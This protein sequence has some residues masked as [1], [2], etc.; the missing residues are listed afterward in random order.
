MAVPRR[1][2]NG[3]RARGYCANVAAALELFDTLERLSWATWA[4][5]ARPCDGVGLDGEFPLQNDRWANYFEDVF[6]IRNPTT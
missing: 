2:R 5:E 6:W 3:R 1:R 4:L